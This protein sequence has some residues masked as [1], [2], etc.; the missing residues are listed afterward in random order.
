MAELHCGPKRVLFFLFCT[1]FFACSVQNSTE[2]TPVKSSSCSRKSRRR[3][4]RRRVCPTSL[5]AANESLQTARCPRLLS[6]SSM[7]FCRTVLNVTK[8]CARDAVRGYTRHTDTC[9]LETARHSGL[10]KTFSQSWYGVTDSTSCN[11]VYKFEAQFQL[12]CVR[13]YQYLHTPVFSRKPTCKTTRTVQLYIILLDTAQSCASQS[14]VHRDQQ[15]A[16]FHECLFYL[17]CKCFERMY[18]SS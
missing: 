9:T 10:R 18:P 5:K 11:L 14:T 13:T 2:E 15:D 17:H 7:N 6:R 8:F 3:R 12:H 1:F 4:R 16:P